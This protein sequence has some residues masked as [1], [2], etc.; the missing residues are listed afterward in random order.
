MFQQIEYEVVDKVAC[1]TLQ[2]PEKFNAFDISMAEELFEALRLAE[3]EAEVRVVLLQGAGKAFCAGADV[4]ALHQA[5]QAGTLDLEPLLISLG[6]I[7][8]FMKRMKK[9]IITAPHGVA[10]GAGFSLALLGDICM[11]TPSCRFVQAFVNIGLVPDMGGMF[12]LTQIVG[13][14]RAMEYSLTGRIVTAE[15][16][17]EAG[18]VQVLGTEEDFASRAL[19]YAKKM[20]DGPAI[21][22]QV[23]KEQQWLVTYNKLEEY[24]D[25]ERQQQLMMSRTADFAEGVAAFTEK[26]KAMF[27]GL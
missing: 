24:L 6:E 17:K 4:S 11:A 1:I 7:A 16:G 15:E 10:A 21:A 8:V 5:V 12:L 22:Y 13:A 14:G 26:R 20:A 9:I 25:K 2:N 18:F 23:M 3:G 27:Q 19:A